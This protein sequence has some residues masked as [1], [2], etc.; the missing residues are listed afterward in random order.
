MLMDAYLSLILGSIALVVLVG[1]HIQ[2]GSRVA[3]LIDVSEVLLTMHEVDGLSCVEPNIVSHLVTQWQ[4]S[5]RRVNSAFEI[6]W[7]CHQQQCW[8][9]V[10]PCQRFCQVVMPIC[11]KAKVDKASI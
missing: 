11:H 1:W 9:T 3:Q 10:R 4:L 5:A 7:G 8:A 2:H 6:N